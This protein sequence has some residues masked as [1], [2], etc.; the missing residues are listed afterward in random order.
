MMCLIRLQLYNLHLTVLA[1]YCL[2]IISTL[3]W[4]NEFNK[5]MAKLYKNL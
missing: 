4:L 5:A 2:N 3:A 1:N